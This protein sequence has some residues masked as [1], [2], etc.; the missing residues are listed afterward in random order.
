MGVAG[1]NRL[2]HTNK[3]AATPHTN[4]HPPTYDGQ[5]TQTKHLESQQQCKGGRQRYSQQLRLQQQRWQE[6][7]DCQQMVALSNY[8]RGRR[9]EVRRAEQQA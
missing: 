8:S 9:G 6:Q 3:Q 4:K 7:G 5:P 2:T 1:R